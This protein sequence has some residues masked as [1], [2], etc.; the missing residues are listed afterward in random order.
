MPKLSVV[1]TVYNL[2]KYIIECLES[3]RNQTFDDY[4]VIIVDD[5]S[6]DTSVELITEYIS[7][8]KLDNFRLIT[9]ENGG[10]SSARNVGI[11]NASGEWISFVD[12]DDWVEPCFLENLIDGVEENDAELSIVAY[13]TYD[14]QASSVVSKTEYTV[15]NG[16]LPE[17]LGDLYSFG[18]VWAR[19]YKMSV[20]REHNIRF[21]ERIHYC[22]DNAFN[23]DFVRHITRFKMNNKVSYS[24]RTNRIG[25]LTNKLIHPKIKYFLY[26]HMQPFCESYDKEDL[27]R[28]MEK[29]RNLAFVMWNVLHTTVTNDILDGKIK[30]ARNYRK[31]EISK[32]ITK[33]YKPRNKKDKLFLLLFKTSFLSLVVLVKIYYGNF[34][35][36]RHS[37]FLKKVS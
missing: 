5:K 34:E 3:V 23:F 15:E 35:R 30:K 22:E 28:G 8:N 10:I 14:M 21:D 32:A 33:A 2:E 18:K 17:N 6:T 29:N 1:V 25:S 16:V 31:T 12:G 9:K 37:K 4:E 36:L 27:V 24:Y 7:K 19:M 13:Q 26:E 20:I 11:E